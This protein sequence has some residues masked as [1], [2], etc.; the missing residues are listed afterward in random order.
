[1]RVKT[2]I[3]NRKGSKMRQHKLIGGLQKLADQRQ[4]TISELIGACDDFMYRLE[5]ERKRI[6]YQILP[7]AIM[8]SASRKVAPEAKPDEI[9]IKYRY[10]NSPNA[11][12]ILILSQL[13]DLWQY[14]ENIK[15]MIDDGVVPEEQLGA[16]ERALAHKLQEK[17]E[18][19]KEV[20]FASIREI[21]DAFAC[22]S[23]FEEEV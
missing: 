8:V 19:A 23:Q 22:V 7:V 4:D 20:S 3:L 5:E 16:Y 14:T 15:S 2:L 21:D 17:E 18:I 6:I 1:M 11:D 12:N 10:N 13:F 9:L